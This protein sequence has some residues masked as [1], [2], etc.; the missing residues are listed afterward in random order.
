MS[1]Q[2]T[3]PEKKHRFKNHVA[4]KLHGNGDARTLKPNRYEHEE[5]VR[6]IRA[7]SIEEREF[8]A[9][10]NAVKKGKVTVY[11]TDKGPHS[12]GAYRALMNKDLLDGATAK[13]KG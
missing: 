12:D 7:L 10:T 9:G 11:P 4:K 1:A 5:S 2:E 3:K 6:S 8:V 13:A